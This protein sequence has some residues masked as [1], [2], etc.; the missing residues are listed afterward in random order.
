MVENDS[1]EF[2]ADPE[3]L[4]S[5]LGN[6][7]E[8]I[9]VDTEFHAEYRYRPRLM[10]IQLRDAAGRELLIDAVAI[11]DLRP[12]GA[13]LSGRRLLLHAAI[14]DVPLLISRA[15]MAP[16]A[17][18][19]VA[20]T[21]VLAGFAGL[22]FPLNLGAMLEAVLGVA[23]STSYGL[24]NWEHRPLSDEQVRYAMEDVRH[25][26]D[27]AAALDARGGP[28]RRLAGAAVDEL[29]QRELTD[30]DPDSIWRGFPAA[31]VLDAR[32]RAILGRLMAWRERQARAGDKPPYQIASNAVLLDVAR[33]Q[34]RS[35]EELLM[36]R[37]TPRGVAK[38]HGEHL[39][40][41]VRAVWELSPEAL[42][43][44]VARSPREKALERLLEA[45]AQAV[46][47]R[48]AVAARLLL[49]RWLKSRILAACRVGDPAPPLAG[50]REPWAEELRALLEGGRSLRIGP[51]GPRI[52]KVD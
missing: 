38:R 17:P 35:R 2:I 14:S 52:E 10:V 6:L 48:D 3:A 28:Y 36:N 49:P 19:M 25:L 31:E 46:E 15:G 34:P 9:A 47:L 12:L 50:W 45:W 26:H 20:D 37:K 27:L 32:G 18:G 16:P 30:T 1:T 44:S 51:D 5:A 22:G 8:P 4:S 24:S 40:S 39:V 7:M 23:S 41:V 42:P 13:A 29:L 11:R 33:R 43:A 21:Q